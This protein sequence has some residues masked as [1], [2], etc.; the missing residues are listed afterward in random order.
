MHLSRPLSFLAIGLVTKYTMPGNQESPMERPLALPTS[1]MA[2]SIC[3]P[4]AGNLPLQRGPFRCGEFVT[5]IKY[6]RALCIRP[7]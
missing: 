4:R 7:A 6:C 1:Y 5:L 2:C 3:V